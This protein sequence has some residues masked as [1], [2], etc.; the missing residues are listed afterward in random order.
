MSRGTPAL[1]VWLGAATL[2]MTMVFA[3]VTSAFDLRQGQGDGFFGELFASLLH[4]LD[5]GT[6]ANDSGNWSYLLTMLALTLCGLVI[7]SALIG[8]IAAGIDARLADLRRG[9]SQVIESGHIVILGWSDAV[10]TI[11]AELAIAN[12]SVRRPVVVIL[13]ERDKVAMEEEI[14]YRVPDLRGTRVVCRTGSPTDLG[15]LAL[16]SA[17]TARSV[18]VLSSAGPDPDSEVIKVLLA[19]THKSE[20]DAPIVA[21]I[22]DPDNLETARMVGKGRAVIVDKRGTVARLIV[23][24]SRQSGA[25][26]V[27]IELFDFHG[28]EIYFHA[29]HGLTG[30]RY[31]DALGAYEDVAVLGLLASDGTARLNPPHDTLIGDQALIV[32]AEDDSVL[33]SPSPSA[34]TADECLIART[35]PQS[36]APVTALLLGWNER[37]RTIV[38]ELDAYVEPGSTL[39]VLTEFGE[40]DLPQLANVEPTIVCGPT[41]SRKVLDRHVHAGLDHVIVL[42]YSEHLEVQQADARTLVTLLHVRDIVGDGQV[43][44]VVSELLDDRNR[45]L[46]EVAHVDDVIVSDRILSLMLAQL[47][48]DR[49]LEPVFLDLLDADGAEI[50]LRPAERYVETGREVNFATIVESARRR[51]ETAFGYRSTELVGSAELPS[52]VVVN[53][54]KSETFAV[55]ADDRVL[56]LATD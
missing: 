55:S 48:S 18:V 36:E 30:Q 7:V 22:A 5:P 46:A 33:A 40:P 2:L 49:R 27:Y 23:Q 25:A 20:S 1:V 38:R 42:C 35:A 31:G 10:F 34:S 12:E 29:G 51:G 47:S 26:A 19:L 8:V 54:S 39:T 32:L 13:A 9:R 52:G 21:E 56:V 17:A 37:A 16:S 41:A 24:T 45:P 11:L 4:A 50:Y 53:P 43:P 6:V 28:D 15:D 3:V 44:A 14:R